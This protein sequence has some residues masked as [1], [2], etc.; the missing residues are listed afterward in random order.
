MHNIP[1]QINRKL[2]RI[3]EIQVSNLNLNNSFS[4]VSEVL[5]Y[6]TIIYWVSQ[7]LVSYW[8]A[9]FMWNL[10]IFVSILNNDTTNFVVI[11]NFKVLNDTI[12]VWFWQLW[13]NFVEQDNVANLKVLVMIELF[14]LGHEFWYLI[15]KP[16]FEPRIVDFG[17]DGLP[18]KYR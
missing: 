1:S 8:S 10:L 13:I 18:L 4:N 7:N 2:F 11:T 14:G 12:C 5:H 6:I 15:H 16:L 3:Y 9:S 17:T